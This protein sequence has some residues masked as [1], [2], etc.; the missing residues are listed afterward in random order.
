MKSYITKEEVG[1][2]FRSDH[3]RNSSISGTSRFFALLAGL[4]VISGCS[5][6]QSEHFTLQADLPANFKFSGDAYYAPAAGQD[7]TVPGTGSPRA[8]DRKYFETDYRPEAHRVE[9]QVPLTAR[10][11]GCALV[12]NSMRIDLRGKWREDRPSQVNSHSDFA[13]LSFRDELPAGYSGMPASG[14]KVLRG[15]CTWLFRTVGPQRYIAKILQCRGLDEQGQVLKRLPGGALQRDQ[16]AGQ[17][18]RL[19]IGLAAEEKPAVDD[20]WVKFPNGWKRCMGDG[21]DD[22]YGFCRGNTTDFKSFRMTGGRV[23]TI[24][25]GCTE[26]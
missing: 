3:Q 9:F 19:V 14:E 12:L 15:Q 11:G 26:E 21:L 24:Y 2:M 8:P 5:V 4:L 20:N 1:Q 22:Q 7:C 13:S 6:L 18:V 23:C 25:P 17:T 10:V 16:L